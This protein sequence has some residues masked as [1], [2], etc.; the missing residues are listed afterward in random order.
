MLSL[1]AP[2]V[3]EVDGKYSKKDIIK[4]LKENVCVI[5]LDTLAFEKFGRL[6]ADLYLSPMDTKTIQSVLIDEGYCKI[7][8]GGTKKQWVP[9]DCV[10]KSGDPSCTA[11]SAPLAH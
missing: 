6:M 4:L 1:I 7:Y 11:T 8:G 3:F 5:W 10:L 2:G 9:A